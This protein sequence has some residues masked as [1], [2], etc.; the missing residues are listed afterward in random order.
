MERK[1]FILLILVGMGF[2]CSCNNS[3]KK[4]EAGDHRIGAAIKQQN[5]GLISLN[6]D[7]SDRYSDMTNPTGNTAEWKVVVSKSGRYNVW[8]SSATK[9][10]ND[11]RYK[12]KVRVSL[13]DLNVEAY[14]ACDKIIL[15][16]TDVSYPWFRADS[17]I[18][19]M[20]IENPG[21]FPVQIISE[22]IVPG[23]YQ[24]HNNSAAEHSRL[25]AVYLTPASRQ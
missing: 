13:Q 23:D 24:I 19:S 15:N 22:Q 21:V 17:F 18:G 6:I 11:L 10:T 8:I 14:P 16:S 1:I 12:D 2:V 4:T 5:D 9:D 7:K 25:L 3:S 20:F